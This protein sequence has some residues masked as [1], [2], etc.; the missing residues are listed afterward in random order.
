MDT[1]MML[2]A[3][4]T[5]DSSMKKH[6]G[7]WIRVVA[8]VLLVAVGMAGI[9]Q[10]LEPEYFI[11]NP[12]PTTATFVGFYEMEQD[13]VDVLFLGSSHAAAAFSPQ[14][15]YDGYGITS[16][17][18]G[19]EQQNLLI[20]YYWLKEA[21]RYQSPKVV[22][23]DCLMLFSYMPSEVLN[24]T[25]GFARKAIDPMRW[26]AVKREAIAD[27]CARDAK[28]SA[29]SY[30]FTNLRFHSRW[31]DLQREDFSYAEL[32]SHYELK[33][34]NAKMGLPEEPR[35]FAHL[36]FD[37]ASSREQEEPR[38]IMLEHLNKI[39]QL[40]REKGI[41]VILVKTP[42]GGQRGTVQ[43]YNTERE[44]AQ[45]NGLALYDFN[46]K[47]L[48]E[49]INFN[50][51]EDLD[52]D[53]EHVNFSGASKI[54][55][56]FGKLLAEEYE[57][58]PRQHQ[59]YES[60][61]QYYQ[62]IANNFRMMRNTDLYSY[63]EQIDNSRY[64]VFLSVK[65]DASGAWND[66]LQQKW[67]ALGLTADLSEQADAS[68]YAIISEGEVV[69]EEMGK[70]RLQR[71]GAVQGG[72]LRYEIISGGTDAGNTGS[73]KISGAD[74]CKNSRGLNIV[75]YD[76]YLWRVVDSVTFDTHE[77]ELEAKR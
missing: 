46:E 45:A 26:G 44:I 74:H 73:I 24:T 39:L 59:V 35:H 72:L 10:L 12:W 41:E 32:S 2:K 65:G 25:E 70:Q 9:N 76:N 27:I 6:V 34:Y 23:L 63:L 33:G 57:V 53:S 16:Y 43:R 5:G 36:P 71:K 62:G 30:Y 31:R 20:T 17:N 37:P 51:L 54:T 68:Y 42:A 75:V 47:L 29:A 40:C 4:F 14:E 58:A 8:L 38:E 22:V 19:S 11:T 52:T 67:E 77:P 60:T 55:R 15:L 13:T 64:T 1:D 50:G 18:L 3:L 69:A 66:E 7:F 28:Q 21:L 61:R 56:Y 48:W 49:A